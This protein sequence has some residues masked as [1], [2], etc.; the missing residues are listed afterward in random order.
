MLDHALEAVA[1]AKGKTR[2]DLAHNYLRNLA[3]QAHRPCAL[4][5]TKC[6]EAWKY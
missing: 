4:A 6:N 1:M 2:L 3:Y 5:L